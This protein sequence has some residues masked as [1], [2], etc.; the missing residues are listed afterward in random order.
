MQR[1]ITQDLS[2]QNSNEGELSE[3][4]RKKLFKV[5]EK[6]SHS[7]NYRFALDDSRIA[8]HKAK[9][10]EIK[11]QATINSGASGD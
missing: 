6:V 11:K 5:T 2:S 8:N 10:A 7:V 3:R 4:T 9:I 1:N